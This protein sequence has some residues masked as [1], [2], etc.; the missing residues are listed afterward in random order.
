MTTNKVFDFEVSG[1]I[2]KLQDDSELDAEKLF[3]SFTDMIDVV[4]QTHIHWHPRCRPLLEKAIK[5]LRAFVKGEAGT[6]EVKGV[7]AASRQKWQFG[8]LCWQG[9]R[10]CI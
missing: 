5:T 3:Q 1:R 4:E 6:P 7:F 10:R 2:V 8:C 9:G